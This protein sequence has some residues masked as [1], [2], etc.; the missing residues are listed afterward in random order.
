MSEPSEDPLL[1]SARREMLAAFAVWLLALLY[2]MGVCLTW[3]YHRDPQTL[4]YVL[5]FPDWVFW[6]I[7]VPW[8]TCTLISGWFAFGFMTD[9]S[10]E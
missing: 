5:G 4:T 10:L 1:K 6:G 8:G 9:E 3:G 7:I 2:T